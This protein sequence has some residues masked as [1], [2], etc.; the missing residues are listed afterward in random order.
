MP[1][2]LRP[3]AARSPCPVSTDFQD[4]ARSVGLP[5]YLSRNKRLHRLKFQ[6]SRFMGR[7]AMRDR[8]ARLP[9]CI[10]PAGFSL[11]DVEGPDHATPG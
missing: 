4:F 2:F 5:H 7:R 6:K 1:A 11:K 10:Q 3:R 8:M 9:K